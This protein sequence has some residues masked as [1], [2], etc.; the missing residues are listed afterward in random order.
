MLV[1]FVC[2]HCQTKLEIEADAVGTQVQC[3]RCE[4]MVT[5]PKK[6][7]GPGMTIGGFKIKKL[8]G[9]GAM[10]EVY[11]AR[12][13]SMDRDVALKI[14]PPQLIKDR[15]VVLNFI[16][17]V[18]L[19]AKLEHP[20][21][22]V[23]H[24]AGEDQGVYFLAMAYVGESLAERL[25][26]EKAL[27]QK[28][29]LEIVHKL[30][31]ALGYAWDEHRLLHRDIKPGNIVLDQ[32]GNP[33]LTDLGLS[34]SLRDAGATAVDEFIVGT[35]NYM[36]P[37]Q[38]DGGVEIDFRADMYSLGATLYHM[39]TGQIPF[40]GPN[41]EEILEKQAKAPLADP[42][43]YNETVTE[44]CV[45]LL[46]LMLAKD[47]DNRHPSWNALIGDIE[48]VMAGEHPSK[49]PLE[50]GE[51]ALLKVRALGAGHEDHKK[52]VLRHSQVLKLQRHGVGGSA[53]QG[54]RP[55]AHAF[56]GMTL[57]LAVVGATA[58]VLFWKTRQPLEEPA[59][60]SPAPASQPQAAADTET[61]SLERKFAEGRRYAEQNPDDF[62]GSI[63]WFERLR[64]DGAGTE[65]EIKASGEIKKLEA[66][67]QAAVGGVMAQLRADA[68]RLFTEGKASDAAALL[69]N[70]SG[71][72]AAE[73]QDARKALA[74]ALARRAGEAKQAEE[75]RTT[76][77]RT[78]MAELL[79]GVAGDLLKGD[80]AEAQV[81]VD[82]AEGDEALQPAAEELAAL[83]TQVSQV[84][85]LEKVI[86]DS[87]RQDQG[88]AVSIAFK[89]GSQTLQIVS[90]EPDKVRARRQ[91][92][93][94]G[95]MQR[96]FS[97]GELNLEEQITRL[98]KEL[99]PERD[100]MRGLL[101][102]Q[103]Q[104]LTAAEKYFRRAATPLANELAA[105][106]SRRLAAAQEA[107][108]QKAFVS[109]LRTA[110]LPPDTMVTGDVARVVKRTAYT[111][112]DVARIRDAVTKFRQAYGST[113]TARGA[114]ALLGALSRV[115]TVPREVEASVLAQA[116]KRIQ[117]A[118][119]QVT[120]LASMYDVNNEG[121][122]MDLSKNPELVSIAPLQGL[123]I[124]KLN[125]A[126]TKVSD[127]S[128]LRR[129]P[130]VSL[131]LNDCKVEQIDD[132][133]GM[134]LEELNLAGCKVK[135]IRVL[136]GM[137]LKDLNLSGNLVD[138]VSTLGELPLKK[139][140]LGACP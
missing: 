79:S 26:R 46:T 119:P 61:A 114:S 138:V 73:T 132:L 125:L 103:W 113:E 44:A 25:D 43:D 140:D 110:G 117:E 17:E 105:M 76:A 12:Q 108:A 91:L 50:P 72:L 64:E 94:A 92:E 78:K 36:S 131:N 81:R 121:I 1:S 4:V 115:G 27:P 123:P 101:L 24:E 109:V 53:G 19:Q 57:L 67:R 21:I 80:A 111:P 11:L 16:K 95:Y 136:K 87:F 32:H 82:A 112:T 102:Y 18:R 59:P 89:S 38:A 137:P 88:K 52:I 15:D 107:E 120:A 23:A 55:L 56:A 37:E 20:N 93:T 127:L 62:A 69:S 124:T 63:R 5:I 85:G 66:A 96:S 97:V 74:D 128:P 60:A 84:A 40:E 2:P 28:D 65:Y 75:E 99:T 33:R 39:L 6:P 45:E 51:S 10:G 71:R 68:E 116:V 90:V 7:L 13:I 98:G 83:R 54:G 122:E 77:A 130:L 14:L 34:K 49:M 9:R 106:V 29:A 100:V 31:G 8:L 3:P 58:L 22:V 30:A 104:K 134:P 129:M 70:Y 86:L 139:L 126:K 35:P 135:N 118:N 41:T 42:R 48:R 47:R 133:E